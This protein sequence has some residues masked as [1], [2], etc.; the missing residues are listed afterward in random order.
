M[1]VAVIGAGAAGLAAAW[2]LG[3]AHDVVLYEAADQAGGHALSGQ[4]PTRAGGTTRGDLG[5]LIYN[6]AFY[7]RL[8]A[9]LA[10][11]GVASRPIR[12][13]TFSVELGPDRAWSTSGVSTPYWESIRGEAGRFI[14]ECMRLARRPRGFV[15]M[16]TGAFLAE[17]GFSD[18]FAADCVAALTSYLTVTRTAQL[19]LPILMVAFNVR[20]RTMGFEPLSTW[21]TIDQGSQE[22]VRA[23]VDRTRG[24]VRLGEPVVRVD[25]S[26]GLPVCTTASGDEHRCDHVVLATAAEDALAMLADPSDQER[27]LL[28][29]PRYTPAT[30][31][32]HRDAR[33][34]PADER[35]WASFCLV[36][37]EDGGSH[38][39]YNMRALQSW[40][41]DPVFCTIDPPEGLISEE[42]RF[43][44]VS[45]RHLVFD[46]AH[47][48]R[49]REYPA[50]QGR[51]R[52][53]YCGAYLVGPA[54]HENAWVSG[55]DVAAALGRAS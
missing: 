11:L 22:Y 29:A 16:S 28:G 38:L 46:V 5:F 18:E 10:S 43:L 49:L 48:L 50:L 12:D 39:T 20:Q 15:E 27:R 52:T 3:E 33:L 23:V 36:R 40:I 26:G 35:L 30:V 31:V 41:E 32:L 9:D 1:R 19:D 17:R 37:R 2:R 6:Q 25:R 47:Q 4:I 21:Y 34:M 55:L 51:R 54:S 44:S 13:L 42:D 14:D 7:P 45:W 24:R 53:W 8:M